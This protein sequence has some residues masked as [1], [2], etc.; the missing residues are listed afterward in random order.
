M[1]HTL[2]LGPVHEKRLLFTLAGIQFTHILDFMIIMPLAPMLMRAFHLTTAQFGVLVS[3]YTFAAATSAILAATVIDRFNRRHV[4]LLLYAAFIVSTALCAAAPSYILLLMARALAGTF[5]GVLGALIYT[6]VGDVIPYQRRGHATGVVMGAFA[7]STVAGVPLGLLLVNLLP[8]LDWRAPFL[9]TAMLGCIFWWM[10]R[11][12]LPSI[13]SRVT[14]LRLSQTLK[15]LLLVFTHANH[16]RA[17]AF[18]LVLILGGFTVIPYIT[19]YATANM[20]FPETY[21]P[22]MYLVGGIC[23]FFTSRLFGRLADRY[24]KAQTFMVIGGLS[25]L[26]ILAITHAPALPV[27]GVLCITTPFFILVSGRFVPAMAIVTSAA[28]SGLRGTFMSMNSATQSVGSAI[29][30]LLAGYILTTNSQGMIEH[31]D[32]VG[33]IACAATLIAIWLAHKVHF[34]L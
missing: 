21:L 13:P 5:G 18:M 20:G 9:F 27:W 7:L 4:M 2:P 16:W 8:G 14:D 26:P 33:Y 22:L 12:A 30:S 23:T 32:L 1:P 34:Q 29:A 25:M 15:P 10:G 28:Q 11:M 6:Y 17:L 24:G 19:L 31:Y 3:S